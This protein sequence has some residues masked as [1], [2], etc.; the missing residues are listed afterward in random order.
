MKRRKDE[1]GEGEKEKETVV[2][3]K[4]IAKRKKKETSVEPKD[5]ILASLENGETTVYQW[6]CALEEIEN[7][8][9]LI[10]ARGKLSKNLPTLFKGTPF[11]DLVTSPGKISL[12]SVEKIEAEGRR[13]STDVNGSFTLSLGIDEE[14]NAKNEKKKKEEKKEKKKQGDLC[15]NFSATF[16]TDDG[17]HFSFDV[18]HCG[19]KSKTLS[20]CSSASSSFPYDFMQNPVVDDSDQDEFLEYLKSQAIR[21]PSAPGK[22]EKSVLQCLIW[23]LNYIIATCINDPHLELE[24]DWLA[25]RLQKLRG[26]SFGKEHRTS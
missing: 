5:I 16:S 19:G 11:E 24:D 9:C 2:Q 17:V 21:L 6:Q 1:E 10:A 15:F 22:D 4:R 14:L 8:A 12:E 23:I 26:K 25:A 13:A 3:N 7:E 18:S 20:D